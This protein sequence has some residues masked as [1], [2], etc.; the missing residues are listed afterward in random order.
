MDEREKQLVH[1]RKR[2]QRA[3]AEAKEVEKCNAKRRQEKTL[4]LYKGHVTHESY[5][6]HNK[7]VPKPKAPSSTHSVINSR[8]SVDCSVN[9]LIL[10]VISDIN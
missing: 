10:R 5:M 7:V 4:Y 1:E 2:K 8:S 9:N 6:L 3:S